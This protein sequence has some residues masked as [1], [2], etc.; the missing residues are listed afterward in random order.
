METVSKTPV[1]VVGDVSTC[2]YA[3]PTAHAI[4]AVEWKISV[5]SSSCTTFASGE[6]DVPHLQAYCLLENGILILTNMF[7]SQHLS[8]GTDRPYVPIPKP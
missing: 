2:M 3:A 1:V 4:S 7:E 8:A 6:L 5:V